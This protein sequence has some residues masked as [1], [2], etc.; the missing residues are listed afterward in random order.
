MEPKI[1]VLAK[2]QNRIALGVIRA[3]VILHPETTWDDIVETFPRSI[4][5]DSGVKDNFIDEDFIKESTG[6]KWNGY[7]SKDEEFITLGDGTH[8]A[9]V[10]M[11]TRPSLERLLAKVAGEGIVA[12]KV[13]KLPEQTDILPG[14]AEPVPAKSVGYVIAYQNGFKPEAPLSKLA[15]TVE[16]DIRDFFRQKVD[17]P[18]AEKKNIFFNEFD[19]QMHLS[20]Y[21]T[22]LKDENG[23]PK[24]DDVDIEYF[25]PIEDMKKAG[26]DWDNKA[27][28]NIDIVVEKDDEY[29]PVEL[30]YTTD[31]VNFDVKRF[32][33]LL[34][35]DIDIIKH[36]GAS[37]LVMY[38]FWKDVKR[39]E[40]LKKRFGKVKN[41]LAL[42]VTN[43]VTYLK[44]PRDNAACMAFSMA[45][46]RHSREKHW[47]GQPATA[48]KKPDFEV[49]KD[50]DITW[51]DIRLDGVDFHYTL[52]EV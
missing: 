52:V 22:D 30:K 12:E 1:K 8:L 7:F 44:D 43:D 50:Y 46:G 32:G 20:I 42:F 16:Q 19:L 4:N 35:K 45:N 13:D 6:E 28:V 51:S 9:V 34:G 41:G 18:S 31:T 15:A 27:G 10:S 47:Q 48:E 49:S 38:N 2:S 36:Q 14:D 37:N 23:K 39:L 33:E 26:Y 17:N 40:V 21:L 25:I 29:V 24:Y 5:P 11:W 3:Y